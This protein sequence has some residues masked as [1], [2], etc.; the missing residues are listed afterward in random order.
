MPLRSATADTVAPGSS[1][2]VR[3]LTF[4]SAVQRLRRST[5]EMISPTL[6][7]GVLTHVFK[8]ANAHDLRQ[9]NKG[10]SGLTLTFEVDNLYE[11]RRLLQRSHAI[12]PGFARSYAA[13]AST[14]AVAWSYR[15][16]G[17]FLRPH[18]L[19]H[20]HVSPRK[21]VELDP[22]LP[23]AHACLGF[24][25]MWKGEHDAS[26]SAFERARELNPNFANWYFG[27]ALVRAGDSP[28]ALDVINAYMR[29]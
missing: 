29:L 5:R 23:S 22:Y 12:D 7:I 10:S 15:L 27:T 8:D 17:D 24:V 6:S 1:A 16:D 14:Y 3:T 4:C 19:D 11:V 26:I 28:R 9:H 18:A 25:L 2:S 13:M 21:A 20:A